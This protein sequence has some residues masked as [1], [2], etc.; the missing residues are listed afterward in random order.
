MI[1]VLSK[2]V[3]SPDY[4]QITGTGDF[5]KINIKAGYACGLSSSANKSDTFADSDAGGE[6]DPHGPGER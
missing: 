6:L 5:T 1:N 2:S 3:E 4:V